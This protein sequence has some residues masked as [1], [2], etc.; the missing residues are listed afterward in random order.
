MRVRGIRIDVMSV[1]VHCVGVE[2]GFICSSCLAL[3]CAVKFAMEEKTVAL[4]VSILC[5]MMG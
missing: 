2:Y 5:S 1:D 4:F 3:I